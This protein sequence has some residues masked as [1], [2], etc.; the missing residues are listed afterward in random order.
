M[1][2]AEEPPHVVAI[3]GSPRRKGNSAALLGAALAEL[4]LRGATVE[5]I[6]LS[7]HDIRYCAGHDDCADRERCPTADDAAELLE[8]FF[9]ADVAI[10]ASPVYTDNVSG[11]TKVF[12]DRACHNY[13][14]GRRLRARAIGMI[15]VADSTGLDDTLAA[16]SRALAF[17]RQDGV[18]TY[19][20]SGYATLLGDAELDC[21]LMESAR[22]LGRDMAEAL[23]PSRSR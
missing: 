23:G 12:F 14:R 18:P 4:E 3:L 1:T 21:A 8:R 13:A 22:Q 19:S 6:H 7:A 17:L 2:L 11:Q 16:I 5:T 15:A 10:V 9:D 20:A